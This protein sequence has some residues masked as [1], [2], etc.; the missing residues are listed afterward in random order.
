VSRPSAAPAIG[1]GPA[2]ASARARV[3]AAIRTA[4]RAVG[5]EDIA[6]AVS[7]GPNA[8]RHHLAGLEAD[9]LVT[10]AVDR[11][12]QRGRPRRLFAPG[13]GR[14]GPYERLALALLLVRRTG[15]SVEEAGRAVAPDGDLV[16][17]LA[18]DGF[19]PRPGADGSILLAACPLATGAAAD[20][21][22]VCGVHQGLVSA[23]GERQGQP[24][25]LVAGRPGSCRV[26]PANIA[27]R[28]TR[29]MH[30]SPPALVDRHD[31]HRSALST[32]D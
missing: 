10:V 18:A 13:P 17:I 27:L 29:Q 21:A 30:A 19:D 26:I 20:P 16:E 8:V 28:P 7:L 11:A 9:G 2:P 5:V 25:Q 22:A 14:G 4:G 12:G 3:L 31:D 32:A 1:P 24:M 6:A 15:A 23:V